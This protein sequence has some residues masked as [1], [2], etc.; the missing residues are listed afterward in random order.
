M[1]VA[2]RSPCLDLGDPNQLLPTW[3]A[4]GPQVST[5]HPVGRGAG[6]GRAGGPGGGGCWGG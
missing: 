1:M 4:L 3:A 5:Q 2:P 6:G